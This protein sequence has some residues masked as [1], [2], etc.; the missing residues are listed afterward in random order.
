MTVVF[1][2]RAERKVKRVVYDDHGR[3]VSE[4]VFDGIKT[5][6]IDGSRARLP[7]GIHGGIAVYVIDGET[8]ASKQGALLVIAPAYRG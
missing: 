3:R 7:A 5:V 8:K 1:H 2:L 6:V 4:D